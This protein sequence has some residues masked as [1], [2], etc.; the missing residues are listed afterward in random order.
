MHY[1]L[2]I[3]DEAT[4]RADL[5]AKLDAFPAVKILAEAAT[6]D[7]ASVLLARTDYDVVFLDI[8]LIGGN[9]FDLVSQV[10]EYARIIF[11]TAYDAHALR[12]FEINAL[13]FL[14]KPVTPERL[15]LI[16]SLL[17][18]RGWANEPAGSKPG[19]IPSLQLED[20]LYL[21][22]G[23]RAQFA[24]VRE[25]SLISAR[26]N[27]SE[28]RL[29]HGG[30]SFLR[31]SLT[32]WEDALPASHFVRVHRTQIVNLAHVRRYERDREEHTLLEV[33]GVPESVTVS[34]RRWGEIHERLGR[35][36]PA[37]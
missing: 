8:Q 10:S 19:E 21:R 26:D 6:V 22:E 5:R 31:K 18:E 4:A 30:K 24:L 11:V 27:Y 15:A 28:V 17:S 1:V 23:L 25:I 37:I 2:L 12:A 33:E 14:L 13:D 7:E 9:A 35:L 34:R 16:L 20:R 29:V 36:H 32:S 3:G